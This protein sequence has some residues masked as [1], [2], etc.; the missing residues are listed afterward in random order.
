[1]FSDNGGPSAAD[2]LR[3]AYETIRQLR[4][5]NSGLRAEVERLRKLV[6]K[7]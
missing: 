4:E 3:D 2:H 1:M 7:L 5:E 6:G